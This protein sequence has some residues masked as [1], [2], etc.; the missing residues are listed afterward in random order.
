MPT[1]F[2]LW[3]SII[4]VIIWQLV[5]EVAES[6]FSNVIRIRWISNDV[7]YMCFR[8]VTNFF[9]TP[10]HTHERCVNWLSSQMLSRIFENCFVARWAAREGKMETK[11]FVSCVG[12]CWC[13]NLKKK[14]K[15]GLLTQIFFFNDK[16]VFIDDKWSYI[17]DDDDDREEPNIE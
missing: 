3:N 16:N 6:S 8:C 2:L 10:L 11:T 12:W 1:L 17:Y 4:P 15:T 5:I 13:V 14:K 7:Q 9:H